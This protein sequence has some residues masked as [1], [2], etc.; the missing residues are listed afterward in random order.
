MVPFDRWPAGGNGAETTCGFI[1]HDFRN[2]A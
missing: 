1:A 2:Y